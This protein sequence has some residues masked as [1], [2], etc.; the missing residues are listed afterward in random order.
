[1]RRKS[2][3]ADD[4]PPLF[5]MPRTVSAFSVVGLLQ[6]IESS[7]QVELDAEQRS[8]LRREIAALE[9][10]AFA[11]NADANGSLDLQSPAS[12]WLNLALSQTVR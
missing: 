12:R 7:P 4:R 1:V 8:Q 10:A 9:R 11:T 5:E 2:H 6:R 3:S